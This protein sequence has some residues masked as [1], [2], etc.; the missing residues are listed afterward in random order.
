MDLMDSNKD[1][2]RENMEIFT[3]SDD[4]ISKEK[5]AKGLES[6]AN[7]FLEDRLM[8]LKEARISLSS[9]DFDYVKKVAH[10]WKGYSEP[11]GF[12]ILGFIGEKLEETASMQK[13]SESLQLLEQ[14]DQYLLLKSKYIS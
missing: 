14:V 5:P 8:E 2:Q 1:P 10:S 6:F 3:L 9:S 13:K 4:H 11:Y 12:K 7:E